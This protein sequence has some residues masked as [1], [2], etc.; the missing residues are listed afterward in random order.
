MLTLPEIR[1]IVA[2][3]LTKHLS[4]VVHFDVHAEADSMGKPALFLEA[5]LADGALSAALK[6]RTDV[7]IALRAAL[8]DAG[9]ERFPFID[10]TSAAAR[11]ELAQ[12]DA[13]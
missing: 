6:R 8:I 2:E 5:E 9:E 13:A 11:A 10:L 7:A 12:D 1:S 3:V 4:N